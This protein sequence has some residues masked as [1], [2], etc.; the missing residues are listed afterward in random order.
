MF[1]LCGPICLP[2]CMHALAWCR[3]VQIQR[4]TCIKHVQSCLCVPSL[5]VLTCVYGRESA[6]MNMQC[7]I[8]ANVNVMLWAYRGLAVFAWITSS[9]SHNSSWVQLDNRDSDNRTWKIPQQI[10]I[11]WAPVIDSST[12]V[13]DHSSAVHWAAS[14]FRQQ[15]GHG[16]LLA[17]LLKCGAN[18]RQILVSHSNPWEPCQKTKAWK[19]ETHTQIWYVYDMI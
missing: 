18:W 19:H 17:A 3:H 7:W 14:L 15:T 1:A 2:A 10:Y 12:F 16:Q 6:Q 13:S 5:Y 8:C 11:W 4:R 9:N